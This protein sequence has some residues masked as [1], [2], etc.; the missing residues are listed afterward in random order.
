MFHCRLRGLVLGEFDVIIDDR[1]MMHFG[2]LTELRLGYRTSFSGSDQYT[3]ISGLL[4][5]TIQYF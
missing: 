4:F 1:L 3:R 2:S 5:R